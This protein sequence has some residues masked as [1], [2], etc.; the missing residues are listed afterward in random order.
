MS[1]PTTPALPFVKVENIGK[2]Y[3]LLPSADRQD[4]AQELWSLKNISFSL[5]H[6]ES[7]GIIGANGSGKTTLLKILSRIIK[8]SEGHIEMRGRVLSIIDLGAGFH[9]DLS[10]RENIYL[11]AQLMLDMSKKEVTEQLHHI[12]EFS[13]LSGFIDQPVKTYSNGMYLR[14]V[15]SIAFFCPAD[16]LVID[17]IF[18]AGDSQFMQKCYN[19]MISFKEAGKTIVFASHNM[20]DVLKLCDQCIWL[21]NGRIKNFGESEEI[22]SLYQ[23]IN[24]ATVRPSTSNLNACT[25]FDVH[26]AAAKSVK[27]NSVSVQNVGETMPSAKLNYNLPIEIKII[28]QKNSADT[29]IGF[30]LVLTDHSSNSILSAPQYLQNPQLKIE[31]DPIG[32]YEASCFIPEKLLN[33]G[34]YNLH[35]RVLENKVTKVLFLTDILTVEIISTEPEQEKILKITPVHFVPTL[36]WKNNPITIRL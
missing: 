7:L 9:P 22:V 3:R 19:K 20:S 18:S 34:T 28:Y 36:T 8:P 27:I 26:N 11:S 12:I 32:S 30:S 13:E 24:Y 1:Q 23:R 14:L 29:A 35:L 33:L 10:G 15:L 25:T 6:G 31:P 5:A 17:E 21:A 2:C 4:D 16:I